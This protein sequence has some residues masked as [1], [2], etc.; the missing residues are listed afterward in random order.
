VSSIVSALS[1]ISAQGPLLWPLLLTLWIAWG[2]VRT[3]SIPN[4]LTIGAA[5][6][7]LAYQQWFFGWQGLVDGLLGL[8]LGF[9]LLV[10]PYLLKGMGAG[11]VK[12]L[13]ALG[14]W[15]GPMRT[16]LLFCYMGFAGALVALG[17]L[18]WRGELLSRVR[19]W[20]VSLLNRL[21]GRPRDSLQKSVMHHFTTVIPY[22]LA[23]ALGMIALF[24]KEI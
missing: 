6:A 22:G 20:G 17:M 15:L 18:W 13:A 23:I 1:S 7:G 10:V 12:A 14:A 16:L 21:R 4:Y 19:F 8:T 2:D 3:R 9:A 5:L 24:I 11:D